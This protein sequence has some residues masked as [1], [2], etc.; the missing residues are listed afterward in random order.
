[1]KKNLLFVMPSLSAGGGERS[2]VNLLS[3]INYKLY[4][5][6]L[7]LFHHEGIF[8]EYVPKEVRILPIQEKYH[9]F[10]LPLFQSIKKFVS[11]EEISL[12]YNRTLFFIKNRMG[13]NISK[14]EQYNWKYV[15]KSLNQIEKQYDV[16]IGFLEKTSTYFCVDK[17]KA[18]K[19]I[20][21]V[22][23]DYNKLGMDPN[24]DALYFGKLDN[25]VTV[26]E[27][28]ANVLVNKF[29][30]KQSEINVIYNIVSPTMIHKMAN[31]E[32][33]D[34]YC[35]KDNEIIILSIGRLHYQKGFEM[36]IKSCKELVDK[37]Y[38]IRW[39]IIGEGAE[40]EK[41]SDLI[42]INK[43]EDNIKLLGLKSNPYPYIK[44]ADIYVQPS[45]FEGKSI[46][47]DEAKIFNKP[48]LVTNF[49][50]AKDQIENEINGL[51]VGMNSGAISNGIEKLIKDIELK[52]KLVNNLT[53]ESLGTE[54]EI[55]KLYEIFKG[56][57]L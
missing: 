48:I 40:R 57:N 28:C 46:A 23:I 9:T 3:Q 32:N 18:Y 49:S 30:N 24:F 29:P 13:G 36:A 51:I 34:V 31:Q 22:H 8:M 37:G 35:R 43:L 53:N 42:K 19:K 33:K 26:S 39:N 5:V 1:M 41:L 20:G 47:I 50:T 15:S 12:A 2:L 25:I 54:E 14:K 7:F 4:N 16:A 27:E 11:N 21:W 55:D 17:V 10:T 38:K 6:D 45:R 52:N 44:Q 56:G